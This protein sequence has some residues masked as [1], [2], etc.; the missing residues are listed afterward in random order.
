MRRGVVVWLTGLPA[1]GKTTIARLLVASLRARGL[2]TLWLDSDELRP[3]LTPRPTYS[4][5]E[6]DV[7]YGTI[8]HVAALAAE[9]GTIVVVSAT[10]TRR[11]YREHVRERLGRLVEVLVTAPRD[12]C[13]RRDPKG[14][15]ARSAEGEIERL[16]GVGAEYEPPEAPDLTIDTTELSAAEAADRILGRLRAL[17]ATP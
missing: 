4:E 5:E 12:V 1:T 13:V 15:Y 14:L 17:E 7:F 16:P 10:A 2:P 9:G 3:V 6:R 11:R 8:G